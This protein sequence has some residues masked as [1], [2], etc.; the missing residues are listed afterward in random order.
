MKKR[1]LVLFSIFILFLVP[2][3][4]NAAS[5]NVQISAPS[6]VYVGETVTVS[7]TISSSSSLGSW[8]YTVAYDDSILG[9]SSQGQTV[10]SYADNSGKTSVTN[11]WTFKAK[12]SGSV[13]FSIPSIVVYAFDDDSEMSIGGST[14]TSINVVKPSNG[15]SNNGGSNGGN[16]N[17]PDYSYKYSDDNS[18]SSLNIEGFDISFDPSITEYSISV[19]NDTK[20]VSVGATASDSNASVSGIGDYDL[21][22]GSNKIEV[23]VTAENGDVRSYIIDVVVKEESPIS[24]SVGDEKFTVVR[25][26]DKLPKANTTYSSSTILIKGESVPCY[27]S[28][29]TDIYLVGLM[30]E[31]GK[32]KLYRYLA[33][34]DKFL[35]Y[36]EISIGSLYLILTDT[37]EVPVGYS[38]GKVTIDGKEYDAFLRDGAYPLLH[39]IN[40]ENGN[41]GF[42][43]YD[44]V[45]KTIQMFKGLATSVKSVNNYVYYGLICLCIFE[46]IMLILSVV[47]KNRVLKKALHNKLDTKTE[48]EKSLDVSYN[49]GDSITDD[50]SVEYNSDSIDSESVDSDLDENYSNDQLEDDSS[51]NDLNIQE[52]SSDLGDVSNNDDVFDELSSSNENDEWDSSSDNYK[53]FS[54]D[55]LGHTALISRSVSNVYN[56]SVNRKEDIKKRKA[57]RKKS[58]S[59]K[60]T[61]EDDM[62][63]F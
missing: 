12:S 60:K 53:E 4:V 33:S 26:A 9:D 56:N 23:L 34:D 50:L 28:D 7:V 15:G 2:G 11:S 51:D 59:S 8:Q 21:K 46:F 19:P 52:N 35:S 10:A 40:L 37:K 16:G 29:I 27:H 14:S 25:K 1:F 17:Q 58:R 6:S 45:D 31:K 30:N 54:D 36:D 61:D 62:F 57:L 22:E 38:V 18:L 5:A 55:T 20:K 32:I 24:V 49:D 48:F 41:E 44:D 39:G 42:Y 63:K 43:S 3:F 47:S 13:S